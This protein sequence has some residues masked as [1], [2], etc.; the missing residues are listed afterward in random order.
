MPNII[1]DPAPGVYVQEVDLTA[2]ATTAATQTGALVGAFARGK[3]IPQFMTNQTNWSNEYL[4]D[5]DPNP[6]YGFAGYTGLAFLTQSDSF[7]TLRVVDSALY[8]GVAFTL[9]SSTNPTRVLWDVFPEGT[10]LGYEGGAREIYNLIFSGPMATGQTF[11]IQITDGENYAAFQ[12]V[13][14]AG[15]W[16]TTIANIAT[17]IQASMDLLSPHNVDAVAEV[18]AAATPSGNA[19][20]IRLY[21]P[22]DTTLEFLNPSFTGVTPPTATVDTD[23]MLFTIFQDNPGAWGNNIG[24]QI[25]N[26]DVGTQQRIRLRF[27]A[28]LVAGNIVNMSVNNLAMESTTSSLVLNQAAVTGNI[29]TATVN[30]NVVTVNFSTTNDDFL[31]DI[32]QAIYAELEVGSVCSVL[33][34][35]NT[36]GTMEREIDISSGLT[37]TITG[38]R[39]TGGVSQ[40]TVTLTGPTTQN[41]VAFI[42]DSDTTMQAIS[43][44]LSAMTSVISAASV[45]VVS[46]STSNDRDIIIVSQVAEPSALTFTN[47]T[48]TG[49]AVQTIFTVT[50]ILVGVLPSGQFEI[51]VYNRS[52]VNLPIEKIRVTLNNQTDGYGNQ[53]N[54][55]TKINTGPYTS[56]NIKVVEPT[57]A[58]TLS[59]V[60]QLYN[61]VWLVTPTIIW[62][63]GGD[64]GN[65]PS[66]ADIINGWNTYFTNRE[67]IQIRLLLNGGYSTP[68]VQQAMDSLAQNR[69][70]CMAILDMPSTYQSEDGSEEVIYRTQV[71]NIDSN[72]S[73]LYTPDVNILDS[74]G[75]ILFVPPSGYV[76][77]RYAY[78]DQVRA[79]WFD[80]AGLQRGL[81]PNILGVRFNYD[82]GMRSL[83]ASNQINPIIKKPGWGWPIFDALTLQ[84]VSSALSN[85]NVRRLLIV[86]EVAITDGLDFELFDPNDSILQQQCIQ[87][88]RSICQPIKEGRGLLSYLPVAD[89]TNNPPIFEDLGQLNVDV[90]LQP[91]IPARKILFRPILTPTGAS[92][93]ELVAQGGP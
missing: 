52:N 61:G 24:V 77:A 8:G 57:N 90:Y 92:F 81:I 74:K 14:W 43:A 51:W 93:Q 33:A 48:V 73:A 30:G 16:P 91:T 38:I 71:M 49:G 3:L 17:E 44:A 41:G 15:N 65:T 20:I 22:T 58:M 75:R 63:S 25:T 23:V 32:A 6:N 5:N 72:Y 37:F 50:E 80:P 53:L 11:S 88:V 26:V 19:L 18:V 40:P 4:V 85:V 7:W 78:N 79:A 29:F 31:T 35:P 70:D 45:V 9:D 55:I 66:S 13:A 60:P 86:L 28:A 89:A 68:E 59:L 39:I 2:R 56:S 84:S 12:P 1:L 27:A 67:T 10:T 54:I 34:V 47:T 64:D 46:G 83:L 21:P 87:I 82:K 76:G 36:D 42:H 62:L 69:M